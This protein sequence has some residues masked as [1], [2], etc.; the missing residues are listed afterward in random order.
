M[1]E[2]CEGCNYP[3]VDCVGLSE[4]KRVIEEPNGDAHTMQDVERVLKACS[5]L[6][7]AK[8][9]LQCQN[10]GQCGYVGSMLAGR[11]YDCMTYGMSD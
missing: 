4:C 6:E 9:M 7:I 3:P 10:E 8:G 5:R 11:Y 1:N 2:P